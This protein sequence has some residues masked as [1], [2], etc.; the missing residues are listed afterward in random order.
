M[1]ARSSEPEPA[2]TDRSM[3][4]GT[5]RGSVT[6][7]RQGSAARSTPLRSGARTTS[8]LAEPMSSGAW[9]SSDVPATLQPDPSA[10][11]A[12]TSPQFNSSCT[13]ASPPKLPVWVGNASPPCP[14][15]NPHEVS[16]PTEPTPVAMSAPPIRP[17]VTAT[18]RVPRIARRVRASTRPSPM[19]IRISGQSSQARRTTSGSSAPACTARGTAPSTMKNTPQPRSPR[20]TRIG[21]DPSRS[22]TGTADHHRPSRCRRT[23]PVSGSGAT[24]GPAWPGRRS[25]TGGV[26]LVRWPS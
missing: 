20:L 23:G 13:E 14:P 17:K 6:C 26:R 5:A 1:P 18:T 10:A 22:A 8:R 25:R 15:P 24:G 11:T 12:S 19:P 21:N 7:Q 9:P 2:L 4:T 3:V 16:P